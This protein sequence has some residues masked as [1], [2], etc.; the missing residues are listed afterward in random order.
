[1]ENFE[2]RGDAWWNRRVSVR[3]KNVYLSA[4]RDK[5]GSSEEEDFL[6]RPRRRP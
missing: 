6:R 2:G 4:E 5:N 1:M 3:L